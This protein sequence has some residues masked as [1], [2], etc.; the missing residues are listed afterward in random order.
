M[1]F[2]TWLAFA[3]PQNL[4]RIAKMKS[5]KLRQVFTALTLLGFFGASMAHADSSRLTPI[6]DTRNLFV[7]VGFDDN[8][9]AVVV[10]D[11]YIG[12]PCQKLRTPV[13]E[14]DIVQKTI[15]VTPMSER[16]G[17]HC[18]EIY[19]PY[20]QVVSL[21]VLPEGRY[22]VQT[23]DER[24]GEILVIKRAPSSSPDDYLYAPV[25]S[26]HITSRLDGQTTAIIQGRFTDTCL[27]MDEA[28]VIESGR[29][30]EV[31][32]IMKKMARDPQGN[33]CAVTD[34]PFESRVELPRLSAGRYLLHVRSLN[35]Q[36]VNQVF[37]K[38]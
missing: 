16:V 28:R 4:K 12:D 23:F 19:V 7:P 8:D 37:S 30:F 26:A 34:K 6:K 22:F 27:A 2:G 15:R 38:F 14:I 32:P 31:L 24:L 20:Q 18:P 5:F 17:N 10:L 25:E 9:E 29:V 33:A 3:R 13:V 21:G 36:S 35:G 11:G 1:K